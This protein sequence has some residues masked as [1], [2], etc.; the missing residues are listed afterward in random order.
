[1]ANEYKI[2]YVLNNGQ[3]DVIINYSYGEDKKLDSY[4][5][6]DGYTFDGWYLNSDCTGE[7]IDTIDTLNPKDIT[8]YAK[9]A[10]NNSKQNNNGCK[11]SLSYSLP[12]ALAG[13][14]I[15]IYKKRK[16]EKNENI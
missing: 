1:M 14:S 2:T 13:I 8:L 5:T 12:L 3:N 9:W 16:E 4:F 15:F 6:K 10:E 11:S 7:R